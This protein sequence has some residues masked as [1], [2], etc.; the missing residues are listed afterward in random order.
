MRQLERGEIGFLAAVLAAARN[1]LAAIEVHCKLCHHEMLL[2]GSAVEGSLGRR[3]SCGVAQE[4]PTAFDL[5]AISTALTAIFDAHP[6]SEVYYV[7]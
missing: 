7:L 5:S 2:M 3:Q 6:L 4:T 1:K